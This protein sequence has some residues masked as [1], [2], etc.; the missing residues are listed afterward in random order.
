M[1]A[2]SRYVVR[3]RKEPC[4]KT[5]VEI[6]RNAVFKAERLNKDDHRAAFAGFDDLS[7]LHA[8]IVL[9]H[10][11]CVDDIGGHAADVLQ[12]CPLCRDRIGQGHLS[13]ERVLSSG[14]LITRDQDMV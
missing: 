9:A 13:R 12:L 6:G 2:K 3:V 14:L 5:V 1:I 4:V 7:E 11:G 10:P 8:E